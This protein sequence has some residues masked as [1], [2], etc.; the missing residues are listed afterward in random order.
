MKLSNE[1]GIASTSDLILSEKQYV[2]AQN[3]LIDYKKAR[4]NSLN[5]L[6][7]LIGDSP[8]NIN[9]Y[10]RIS[11][12]ELSGEFDVPNEI[13]SEIIT[14]RPDYKSLEKHEE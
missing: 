5:A 6:A 10:E 12:D 4:Q 13:S 8:N 1:E 11:Y 14:N 3:D 7:V 2:M 9:N